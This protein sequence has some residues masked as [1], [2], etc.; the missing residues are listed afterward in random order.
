MKSPSFASPGGSLGASLPALRERGR[1][2]AVV[3]D[4]DDT[5]VLERDYVH[6]GYRAVG[7]YLRRT[8]G[9]GER[10]EQWLWQRV[11]AGQSERA[12]NAL[13]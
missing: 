1:I 12:F 9:R 5:L 11:L 13:S 7:D 6:I 2:L 8:T 4:L 10:F 3:F